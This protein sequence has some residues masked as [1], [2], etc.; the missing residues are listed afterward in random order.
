MK[1]YFNNID[2]SLLI[3][4]IFSIIVIVSIDFWLINIPEKVSWGYEFGKI[5]YPLC[6]AYIASFIFYFVTVHIKNVKD[7]NNIRPY[8]YKNA[9]SVI[10]FHT[11]IHNS[12]QNSAQPSTFQGKILFKESDYLDLLTRILNNGDRISPPKQLLHS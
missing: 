9:T 6:M 11:G 12:L 2:K 5:L 10:G 8:I 7:K 4:L 1:K 3:I